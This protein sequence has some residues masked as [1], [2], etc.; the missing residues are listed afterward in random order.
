MLS[1]RVFLMSFS[2]SEDKNK[3]TRTGRLFLLSGAPGAVPA[4]SDV[5]EMA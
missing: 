3:V 1:A 5:R 2:T 4:L